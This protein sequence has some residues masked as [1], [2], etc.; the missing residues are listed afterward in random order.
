MVNP[1]GGKAGAVKV[2][3]KIVK[4]ILNAFSWKGEGGGGEGLEVRVVREYEFESESRRFFLSRF[5]DPVRSMT[6]QISRTDSVSYFFCASCRND[7]WRS[8]SRSSRDVGSRR[9]RVS[10]PSLS[11]SSSFFA[12]PPPFL[13]FSFSPP[14][15]QF[16]PLFPYLSQ[17]H[18]SSLRRRSDPRNLQR[19][20]ISQRRVEMPSNPYRPHPCWVR[21]RAQYIHPWE[22]ER[23]ELRASDAQS[24]QG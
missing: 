5:D 12:V 11:L 14:L 13:P 16:N 3:E 2:A 10:P 24:H 17:R 15:T 18:R 22:G 23:V 21:E 20:R 6:W 19:F 1:F 7:P 9:V 4:P 8:C